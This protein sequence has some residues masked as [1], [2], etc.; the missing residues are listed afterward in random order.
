MCLL[1]T[2]VSAAKMAEQV[3]VLFGMYFQISS[4]S[5]WQQCMLDSH[6]YNKIQIQ[7]RQ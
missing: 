6:N 1:V 5:V 7:I 3:E 4:Y 2:T